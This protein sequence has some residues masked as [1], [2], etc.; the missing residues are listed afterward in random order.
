MFLENNDYL[1]DFI[2]CKVILN[3]YYLDQ[4]DI[5]YEHLYRK[6]DLSTLR[7]AFDAWYG[8]VYN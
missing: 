4:I 5:Y 3:D 6:P 8:E 7:S 1:T 2:S